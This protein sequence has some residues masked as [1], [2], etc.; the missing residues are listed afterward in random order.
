MQ[1]TPVPILFLRPVREPRAQEPRAQDKRAAQMECVVKPVFRRRPH[2]DEFN[3]TVSD[4][5][6]RVVAG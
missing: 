2:Y 5:C 3:T 6:E 1:T 4:E